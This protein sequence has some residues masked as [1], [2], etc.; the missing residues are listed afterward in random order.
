MNKNLQNP[1]AL[2][3]FANLASILLPL[4]SKNFKS[5]QSD[6]WLR[7]MESII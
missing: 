7:L 4:V 5:D 3:F 6:R 1:N 2:T